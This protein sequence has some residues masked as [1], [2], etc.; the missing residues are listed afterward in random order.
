MLIGFR[1]GLV[2]I[3]V[4]EFPLRIARPIPE[5]ESSLDTQG[6]YPVFPPKSLLRTI[7][8]G[9]DGN[10]IECPPRPPTRIDFQCLPFRIL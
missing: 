5:L 6:T 2:L 4:G 10:E 8:A 9:N 7:H 3:F 1:F